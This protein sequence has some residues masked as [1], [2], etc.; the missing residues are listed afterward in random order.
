MGF[1][2]SHQPY[3]IC[4]GFDSIL[5]IYRLLLCIYIQWYCN[6]LNG[7]SLG[8]SG[9]LS[10]VVISRIQDRDTLCCLDIL[11]LLFHWMGQPCH[12]F[13]VLR[14]VVN[15]PLSIGTVKNNGLTHFYSWLI[16]QLICTISQ[17]TFFLVSHVTEGT[18]TVYCQVY[19]AYYFWEN[20][21]IHCQAN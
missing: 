4:W 16:L 6:H 10:C 12:S 15:R 2:S 1:T 7:S 19:Y 3:M 5:F 21:H 20:I 11:D 8:S 17:L 18:S 9:V 14:I 13:Y